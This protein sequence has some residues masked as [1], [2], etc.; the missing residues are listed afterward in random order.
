MY[1]DLYKRANDSIPTDDAKKRVMLRLAKAEKRNGIPA[2]RIG[3]FAAL[4]ACLVFTVAALNIY[5]DFEKEQNK[6]K[7]LVYIH[8][9]ELEKTGTEQTNPVGTSG[10][11]EEKIETQTTVSENAPRAVTQSA[12]KEATP[13]PSKEACKTRTGADINIAQ[14]EAAQM[15]EPQAEASTAPAFKEPIAC[16]VQ[17]IDK[18]ASP[19]VANTPAKAAIVVNEITEFQEAV[20]A[21]FNVDRSIGRIEEV[22]ISEYYE[23]IGKDVAASAKLP[24]GFSSTTQDMALFEVGD[25]GKY[26]GDEWCFVFENEEKSVEIVTTKNTDAVKACIDNEAYKKSTVCEDEAVVF[27]ENDFYKAY[28]ISKDVGY[29]VESI[30][31]LET[32]LSELLISLAE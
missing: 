22:T 27:G 2:V 14:E 28:M 5:N 32:E 25:D 18:E 4:A 26:K 10:I 16:D 21:A 9:Q 19:I 31:L 24:D 15:T 17:D 7:G 1:K 20:P 23:Y 6:D 3:Q 11:G 13:K 12:T 30:G 8:Q 29:T